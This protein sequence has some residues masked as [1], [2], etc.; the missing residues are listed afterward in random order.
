MSNH[1]AVPN[2]LMEVLM[3]EALNDTERRILLFMIRKICGYNKT[4]DR[5]SNSQF[6]HKLNLAHSTVSLALKRLKLVGIVVLVQPGVSKKNPNLW[7]LDISNIETK[8]VD[9]AKLVRFDKQK[10]VDVVI[11]TKDNITKDNANTQK[12]L[13][14]LPIG[15]VESMA[16]Q[17][18]VSPE[19]IM[20]AGAQAHDWLLANGKTMKNYQAF[21]RNWLRNDY[22][23]QKKKDEPKGVFAEAL[24]RMAQ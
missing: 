21:L 9:I 11:H 19:R 4:Q 23:G 7:R 22:M 18:K 16:A 1:A 2:E 12:Y 13:T 15:D 8:L 24:E 6:E 17:F 5:I 20:A 3:S 14:N 10:L